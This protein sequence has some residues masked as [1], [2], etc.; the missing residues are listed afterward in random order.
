[1]LKIPNSVKTLEYQAAEALKGLFEQIP[2]IELKNIEL[3]ISEPDNGV[4]ILLHLSASGHQ[5]V[6]VCDVKANGQPRHVRAALLQLRHYAARF[7]SDTTAIFVAPY[8]S[9]ESQALCQEFDV[10]FLDLQGNAR[11]VFDGVFI[12]RLVASAPPAE[13]RELKSIFKPKATQVLLVM[14]RDPAQAWRVTELAKSADVSLGHVSN[15]RTALLDREWA[16]IDPDGL[17]LAQPDALLE[18]WRDEYEM[19]AGKKLRFYT[20]LHGSAFDEAVRKAIYAQTGKGRIILASFSAAHWL[21]PYGRI[22]THFF[23]A[24]DA[25]LNQLIDTLKLSSSLKGENVVVT[26]PKE[27]G[28]LHDTVTPTAGIVCTSPVR[29][30]LDLTVAGER[31]REAAAHIRHEK[32]VWSK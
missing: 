30:Y 26:I 4:D 31:G 20:S 6:L 12:E 28:V 19:P 16:Q 24:D 11:I 29:T 27:T 25:G 23:Y 18:A 1:M 17:S 32:L 7:G 13:R 14:L 10:G 15:V 21:A 2:S 8:L 5:H 22:G 9:A 3:N